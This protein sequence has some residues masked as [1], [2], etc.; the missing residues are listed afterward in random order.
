MSPLYH[1]TNKRRKCRKRFVFRKI[2]INEYIVEKNGDIFRHCLDADK[3]LEM[4]SKIMITNYS[5]AFK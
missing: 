4:I 2:L 5:A 3:C 1:T